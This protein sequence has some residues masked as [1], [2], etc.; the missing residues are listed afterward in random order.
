MI[1]YLKVCDN[2]LDRARELLELNLDFRLKYAHIFKQRDI[3]SKEL[4]KTA[5]TV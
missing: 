4:F 2:N 3:R 5:K 1:R